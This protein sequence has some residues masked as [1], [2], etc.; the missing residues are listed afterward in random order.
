VFFDGCDADF[1]LEAFVD[2]V[3]LELGQFGVEPIDFG[4]KVGLDVVH[5]FVEASDVVL[6]R[7]VLDDMGK[8]VGDLFEAGFLWCH[9]PEVYH[10]D[11]LEQRETE[12]GRGGLSNGGKGRGAVPRTTR[13][14][15]G[16]GG[17][18]DCCGAAPVDLLVEKLRPLVTTD[19]R[20]M[21]LAA[22]EG[23]KRFGVDVPKLAEPSAA[24]FAL[25]AG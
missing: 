18:S 22:D 23:G 15:D 6:G 17:S 14:A 10:N 8:H 20:G 11:R 13:G 16:A 25:P 24:H 12:V 4:G 7:H 19:G 1:E 21:R 9:T 3:L 5:L 2:F